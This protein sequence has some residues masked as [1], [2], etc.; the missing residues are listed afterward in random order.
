[1]LR[2][3]TRFRSASFAIAAVGLLVMYSPDFLLLSVRHRFIC[4]LIGNLLLFVAVA[5]IFPSTKEQSEAGFL[6]SYRAAIFCIAGACLL[7]VGHFVH[8][9]LWLHGLLD[10]TAFGSIF[11][12]WSLPHSRWTDLTMVPIFVIVILQTKW[13]G[14][15]ALLTIPP[16]ILIAMFVA[17]ILISLIAFRM[18]DKRQRARPNV[19]LN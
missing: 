18:I 9:P 15:S 1:M 11:F 12:C 16:A 10:I 3:K 6:P 4:N 19:A 5:T 7:L 2:E 8:T 17:W 13:K 14:F